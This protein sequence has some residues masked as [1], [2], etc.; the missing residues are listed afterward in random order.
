[1]YCYNMFIIPKKYC[2]VMHGSIYCLQII[3]A[4]CNREEERERSFEANCK[5]EEE[6]E[7]ELEMPSYNWGGGGGGKSQ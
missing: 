6:R 2:T 7:R 4:N 1:M 5:R 3:E